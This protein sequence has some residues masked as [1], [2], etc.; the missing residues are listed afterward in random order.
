MIWLIGSLICFV[1]SGLHIFLFYKWDDIGVEV[2]ARLVFSLV[3]SYLGAV[4]YLIFL[5]DDLNKI[6]W[7]ITRQTKDI[8]IERNREKSYY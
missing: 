7:C 6:D 8:K 4:L 5:I 1:F 2:V 3:F